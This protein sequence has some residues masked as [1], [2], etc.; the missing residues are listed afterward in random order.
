MWRNTVMTKFTIRSSNKKVVLLTSILLGLFSVL[1]PNYLDKLWASLGYASGDRSVISLSISMIFFVAVP[2]L[3][4]QFDIDDLG[5]KIISESDISS[6]TNNEGM[7]DASKMFI[8]AD[9]VLNTR[10]IFGEVDQFD[11]SESGSLWDQRL[12]MCVN[13]GTHFRELVSTN[14][15]PQAW[16]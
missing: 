16:L 3:L 9:L 11:I 8:G 13:Q 12:L 5:K 14:C 2:L 15:E 1:A 6:M 4:I 7:R 10:I